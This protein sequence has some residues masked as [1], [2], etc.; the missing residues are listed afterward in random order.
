LTAKIPKNELNNFDPQILIFHHLLGDFLTLSDKIKEKKLSNNG[1]LY[2]LSVLEKMK[3]K[4]IKSTSYVKK[5][6]NKIIIGIK[7]IRKIL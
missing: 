3:K 4:T 2:L 7:V 1:F 5:P 6:S